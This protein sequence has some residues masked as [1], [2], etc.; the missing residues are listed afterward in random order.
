M[1]SNS[2]RDPVWRAAFLLLARA[3]STNGECDTPAP[4]DGTR[5]GRRTTRSRC[6]AQCASAFDIGDEQVHGV[7]A[8]LAARR[9]LLALS[10]ADELRRQRPAAQ[11]EDGRRDRH[12]D[13]RRRSEVQPDVRQRHG[14]RLRDPRHAVPQHGVRQGRDLLRRL[15]QL[16]RHARHPV[17]Q[18]REGA[19][20][21]HARRRPAGA[22]PGRAVRARSTSSAVADPAKRNLGYAIGA[23]A[24]RLSP[25]ALAFPERIGPMLAGSAA[26]RRRRQH[27][28]RVR[29]GASPGSSWISRSTRACTAR[30][31][32]AP[33]CAPRATTSPTRCRSRTRSAAG[34][35]ASRSSARTPNG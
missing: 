29:P 13:R 33:R 2:W 8:G 21:V 15:P 23:G 16:R 32:C 9:V 20:F 17:P 27:Q 31:T 34:S 28:L 1:M 19:R 18:L 11:R 25:H 5:Q 30:S 7:A 12:R 14:R 35:A 24:Y 6:R 10:H 22:R 26:A 3:V 4:P